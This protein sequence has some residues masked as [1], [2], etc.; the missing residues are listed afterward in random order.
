MSWTTNATVREP[1]SYLFVRKARIHRP[2][3]RP[4]DGG[5]HITCNVV[6]HEEVAPGLSAGPV[7]VLPPVFASPECLS[8]LRDLGMDGDAGVVKPYYVELPERSIIA[9]VSP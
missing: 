3:R 6:V 7:G 1:H 5:G 9:R 8:P 4:C 2:Q